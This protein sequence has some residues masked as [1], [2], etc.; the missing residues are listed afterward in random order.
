[1]RSANPRIEP[2]NCLISPRNPVRTLS[3]SA[4]N[5][6]GNDSGFVRACIRIG[7]QGASKG[8]SAFTPD[9]ARSRRS[10]RSMNG[11]ADSITRPSC[12]SAV[13]QRATAVSTVAVSA[14]A[15]FAAS[16]S[17]SSAS[18]RSLLKA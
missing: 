12:R 13:S 10:R 9:T 5:G 4:R 11:P 16:I 7:S 2:A 6:A 18:T 17:R 14:S 15:R 1:M 3:T 8:S